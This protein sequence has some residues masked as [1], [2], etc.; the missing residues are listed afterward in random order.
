MTQEDKVM[1]YEKLIRSGLESEKVIEVLID[2]IDKIEG[3]QKSRKQ[4]ITA[5]YGIETKT[6]R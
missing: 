3:R 4:K 1:I 2:I 5:I 6:F